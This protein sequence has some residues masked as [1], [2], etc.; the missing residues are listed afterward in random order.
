M[1]G[2][3]QVPKLRAESGEVSF[4]GAGLAAGSSHGE[5]SEIWLLLLCQ[6]LGPASQ[7]AG[8]EQLVLG[9]VAKST[10]WH[11][12]LFY[13]LIVTFSNSGS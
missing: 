12:H 1:P 7:E 10:H 11:C 8:M 3:E 5:K 4:E 13:N 9:G 6:E 2:W